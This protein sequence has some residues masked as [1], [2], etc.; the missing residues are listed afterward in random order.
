MNGLRVLAPGMLSLIEDNGRFGV[1]RYGLSVGGPADLHSYCWANQLLGNPM[2]APTLEITMG[3]ATFFAECDMRLALTGANTSASIDGIHLENWRSFWLHKGQTLKL[4]Y[5][6]NGLRAYLAV[7]GGF[8]TPKTFS[9]SATVMRNKLGGLAERPGTALQKGDILPISATAYQ[10]DKKSTW[11]PRHFIPDYS[12]EL[13][14]GVIESYQ[15]DLFSTS[16]KQQFYATPYQISDK[17]DRMGIRL[18]GEAV[19][20]G[21]SGIV[22]EGIAYG[23][24]QFPPNGQPII[25]LNDRQTLGGYP[26][27]GCLSKMS[28]MKLAQARPG[29]RINFYRADIDLES[30]KYC[31]FVEY[32]GLP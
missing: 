23:A 6:H 24:I 19:D 15:A 21:M 29:S 18:Q 9:S 8:N 22:S 17:F 26:K 4:G 1:A 14:L 30:R 10:A 31:Q 16:A 20:C 5:A 32:F 13:C 25:L 2:N 28:L 7:A 3:N 11:V 27:I 12:N